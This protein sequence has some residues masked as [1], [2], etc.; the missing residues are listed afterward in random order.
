M[1]TG[2]TLLLYEIDNGGEVMVLRHGLQPTGPPKPS[3]SENRLTWEVVGAGV[4]FQLFSQPASWRRL[5]GTVSC[6][7]MDG[8]VNGI[9]NAGTGLARAMGAYPF[10]RPCAGSPFSADAGLFGHD[11]MVRSH[12]QNWARWLQES[13]R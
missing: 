12:K 11:A 7:D 3:W 5:L 8:T 13:S 4:L 2:R 9:M 1:K 6:D 10:A